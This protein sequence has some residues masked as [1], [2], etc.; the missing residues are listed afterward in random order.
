MQYLRESGNYLVSW[1]IAAEFSEFSNSGE[2]ILDVAFVDETTRNY[3]VH[4]ADWVAKPITKPDLYLYARNTSASTHFW[5]SWNGATEV[6]SWRA[7]EVQQQADGKS[8]RIVLGSV[9]KDSFESHISAGK[10][11]EYGYVE[12]FGPGD[13]LL[14]R[15]EIRHV[16]MPG[17]RL[18][19]VCGEE[20]CTMQI[21]VDEEAV[22]THQGEGE[23]Y[24]RVMAKTAM[25]YQQFG[26]GHWTTLVFE[27]VCI[28]AVGTFL[29][30][31]PLGRSF[32][33]RIS[34]ALSAR[35]GAGQGPTAR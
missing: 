32:V 18:Q 13:I 5:M 19:R 24:E 6:I 16:M 10:F 15:S 30:R 9:E 17:D 20:H 28:F 33:R 4:K 11:V 1:G 23:P 35:L 12:A 29:M 8:T 26:I 21:L 3:R 14:A 25:G 7:Y 22:D 34:L 27:A 31:T 2:R